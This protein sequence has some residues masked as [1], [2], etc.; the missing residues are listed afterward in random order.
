[1][2]VRQL[3]KDL[4][5]HGRGDALQT[6]SSGEQPLDDVI[7]EITGNAIPIVQDTQPL[8]ISSSVA[9]F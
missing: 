9:E 2:R 6:E 5:I 8:L 4:L 7:M 1:M 3:L